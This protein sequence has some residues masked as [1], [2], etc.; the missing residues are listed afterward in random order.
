VAT[1]RFPDGSPSEQ[2]I[3]SQSGPAFTPLYSGS[4]FSDSGGVA[5]ITIVRT[6]GWR[7]APTIDVAF[8]EQGGTVTPGT[9]SWVLQTS[10]LTTIPWTQIRSTLAQWFTTVCGLSSTVW[11]GQQV[12]RQ[13]RPFGM[14]KVVSTD[15]YGLADEV[16]PRYTPQ[17]GPGKE[18]T[19]TS[20]GNREMVL[21]CQVYV[22]QSDIVDASGTTSAIARINGA[23]SSLATPTWIGAFQ[24]VGL[25][26]GRKGKP[27]DLSALDSTAFEGRAQW[28]LT[29]WLT[30]SVEDYTTF[31]ESVQISGA[32]SGASLSGQFNLPVPPWMNAASSG[33]TSIQLTATVA[34]LQSFGLWPFAVPDASGSGSQALS[35][36]VALVLN[37]PGLDAETISVTNVAFSGQTPPV[38]SSTVL[39]V[40]CT[41]AAGLANAHN[42]GEEA[43]LQS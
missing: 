26:I 24:N 17:N 8:V 36:P 39:T 15:A 19:L 27:R 34:E 3:A 42:A 31:I 9:F 6:G 41:L 23:V 40:T 13:G 29:L 7:L 16:R 30:D 11:A 28:D 12:P 14:L 43:S 35:P 33:A 38:T 10:V 25:S 21:S 5:T 1:V 2:V 4:S 20:F 18:I 22:G 32:I 37:A